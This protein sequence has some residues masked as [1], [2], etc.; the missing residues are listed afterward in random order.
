MPDLVSPC[1]WTFAWFILVRLRRSSRVTGFAP[2]FALVC[3][4][5]PEDSSAVTVT[6]TPVRNAS[7]RGGPSA[8]GAVALS[9]GR[10]GDARP[11]LS[12]VVA[13][14]GRSAGVCGVGR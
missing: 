9:T 12:G 6:R 13:V 10:S 1:Q 2:R 3:A 14:V 5:A 4:V 7:R 11:V 8:S